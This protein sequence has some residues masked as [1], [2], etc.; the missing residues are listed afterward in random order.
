MATGGLVFFS[1]VDASGL[2]ACWAML[3][4]RIDGSGDYEDVFYNLFICEILCGRGQLVA[5]SDSGYAW[6]YRGRQ[7]D[8]VDKRI[9]LSTILFAI[10]RSLRGPTDLALTCAE[11][12]SVTA[13]PL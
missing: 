9:G 4:R 7:G 11:Q 1:P 2:S 12:A 6:V 10:Y 5:I 13:L 8:H 3:E